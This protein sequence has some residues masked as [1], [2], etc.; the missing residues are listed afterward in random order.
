MST[1]PRNLVLSLL[2]IS[3]LVLA[4]GP[5]EQPSATE[6]AAAP[7]EP[8]EEAADPS[9]V[10]IMAVDFAFVAPAEIPSGWVTFRFVNEGSQE[11]FALLWK[12]PSGK[13]MSD[14]IAEVGETFGAV[15]ERYEAGELD[16]DGAGAALGEEL[17]EWFF[18]EAVASGG[19]ALTEGG[20]TSET[21]VYL[22][23]G[24]YA[25]ECYVKSP[26]GVWHNLMGMIHE[27]TVT[28]E[29]NGAQE[30]A[31][32]IEM[33]LSNYEI[34]VDGPMQAGTQ[35][36]AVHVE[37]TPEGFMPH[38]IN[39]FRIDSEDQVSDIVQWMDWMDLEG[40]RAP[41]PGYSLGGVEHLAAG[42]TG[43]FTVDLDPGLY[44][45]VSEGY[46]AQGMTRTF[47]VE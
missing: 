30:P 6:T 18:T 36:V 38:D 7:A 33:T 31:A 46:G 26:E 22:E 44:A 12:L 20:A 10:E 35:T 5:G 47:V 14:Y 11:H 28:D 3:G 39:L 29:A 13:G 43:Y 23:P 42:A 4:C 17:P 1:V 40:F 27:L 32:D 9:I 25:V 37:D 41:T 19:P 8:T 24:T 16:R 34:T 21:T 2:V 45:W 15:W